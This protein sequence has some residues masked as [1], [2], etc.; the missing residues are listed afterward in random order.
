M[1]DDFRYCPGCGSKRE[2]VQVHP[3]LGRCPDGAAGGCPEWFCAACGA[4]LLI[5]LP[6]E[7]GRQLIGAHA[8]P[9]GG[10]LDRV[11]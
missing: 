6:P 4:A 10:H 2:F 3:R 11:A 8:R 9:A 5:G 7:A 1:T